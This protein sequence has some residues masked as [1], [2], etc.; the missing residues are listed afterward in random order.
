MRKTFILVGKEGAF[1]EVA[2]KYG[3]SVDLDLMGVI[4]MKGAC[5]LLGFPECCREAEADVVSTRT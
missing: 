1:D 5:C 4:T 3:R 2:L